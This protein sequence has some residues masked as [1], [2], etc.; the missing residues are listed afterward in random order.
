MSSSAPARHLRFH[1]HA[2]LEDVRERAPI[3]VLAADES[4]ALVDDEILR[5]HHAAC[6]H[7]L[8]EP[9]HLHADALEQR[10][11]DW[12]L[13][14]E[15][16]IDEEANGDASLRGLHDRVDD[17]RQRRVALLLLARVEA[18]EVDRVLRAG[19]HLPP[20]VER[21]RDV[22][23][24]EH[25]LDGR[26]L[27]EADVGRFFSGR[28]APPRR[29]SRSTPATSTRGERRRD[30][31]GLRA[32][33]RTS[34]YVRLSFGFVSKTHRCF[35][36]DAPGWNP[37]VPCRR[38]YEGRSLAPKRGPGSRNRGR[39]NRRLRFAEQRI[40]RDERSGDAGT[41]GQLDISRHDE[42]ASF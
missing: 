5:M 28:R 32:S 26:R 13:A 29:A 31:E 39:G 6:A 24:I 10:E 4:F 23:R 25:R 40:R 27:H 3:E 20:H 30:I 15:H 18:R 37:S 1:A 14:R 34:S 41:G 7:G 2:H 38:K 21:V 8:V 33:C 11:G 12:V 9:M 16:R 36:R 42:H 19:D 17:R 22:G 35:Y